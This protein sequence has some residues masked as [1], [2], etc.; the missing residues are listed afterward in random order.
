MT[1]LTEI[2][3][4]E[5][6]NLGV[7][8][9]PHDGVGIKRGDRVASNNPPRRDP[10]KKR[11]TRLASNFSAAPRGDPITRN[12]CTALLGDTKDFSILLEIL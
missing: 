9:L 1:L 2:K 5:E 3:L 11:P 8:K 6:P 10:I 12:R 7:F 4:I